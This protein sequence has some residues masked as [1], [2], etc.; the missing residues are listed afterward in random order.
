MSFSSDLVFDGNKNQ[1]YTESDYVNPLNIYGQSK[2][3][4]EA[5]I[6]KENPEALIIRTSAFF[7]P[8]DE[9][10]FVHHVCKT[11]SQFERLTVASD[12][13]VSPTY[14]PDLVHA[15]LD[16]LIDDEKG[17]WHLANDGEISWADLAFL[18]A[19]NFA[20]DK[21]YICP[22]AKDEI[23]FHAKRPSYTVL[24]SEKAVL[25]PTLENAL[26]RYFQQSAITN[27]FL[28]TA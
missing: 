24:S 23:K 26:H 19:E 7:G 20:L 15:A 12:I 25:L 21:S 8:W 4:A 5:L 17:I 9:Y 22:L 13:Y 27:T 28:K 2:A 1:P 11:L 6:Q 3:Q 10:N 18:T 16:L 14:V